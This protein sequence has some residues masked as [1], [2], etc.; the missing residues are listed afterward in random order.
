MRFAS[1]AVLFGAGASFGAGDV[2]PHP[3]PLGSQL[4]DTLVQAFPS[5]WGTL[6]K[7]D[8]EIA[9]RDP[10]VPFE[11]GM[12]L[13]WTRGEP[14]A[15]HLITDL[16]LYFTRFEPAGGMDCYSR[17]LRALRLRN[18]LG[19]TSFASLNY[20]CI[21]ELAAGR[22]GLLV[23][24]DGT[25]RRKREI[26]LIKPHGSCNFVVQGL[27]R[28]RNITMTNVQSGPGVTYYEG[29][30]EARRPDEIA[31]LYH[32]GPS[33][34]PAISLYAPGKPSPMAPAMLAQL[35]QH[36][37]TAVE[38]ATVVVV[39]GARVVLADPHVWDPITDT[40]CDV[41]YV[42]KP[43]GPDFARFREILADRLTMLADTFDL[44]L[45]RLDSRLRLLI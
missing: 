45:S 13:I 40:T 3:P 30:I 28:D 11:N 8:E 4:Y 20:D 16:A 33:I 35:R 31:A 1:Y 23:N 18:V 43:V 15:Q 26:P 39:I 5:T 37:S 27:G 22:Q 36:W 44:A 17:L 14:R 34:P 12:G 32:A 7:P 29:P 38:G 9:F 42:G 10:D 24:H 25:R 2:S 21:F 19:R 6:V 41:W